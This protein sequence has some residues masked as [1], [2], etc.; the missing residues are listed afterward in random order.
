MP[1]T[2]ITEN[3]V[4]ARKYELAFRSWNRDRRKESVY[5]TFLSLIML[6]DTTIELALLWTKLAFIGAALSA[7]LAYQD[8]LVQG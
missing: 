3:C 2:P 6:L 5:S 8:L 7:R 4:K 1:F